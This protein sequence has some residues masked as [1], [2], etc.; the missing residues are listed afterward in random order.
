MDTDGFLLTSGDYNVDHVRPI[1]WMDR[2]E[3]EPIVLMMLYHVLYYL[4]GIATHIG[5][6][7]EPKKTMFFSTNGN[8]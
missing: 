5:F 3:N 8:H 2:L 6:Q 1:E 7:G 4:K